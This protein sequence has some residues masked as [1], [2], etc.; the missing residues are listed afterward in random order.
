M[1]KGWLILL[2][3]VVISG[4]LVVL[5]SF[6]DVEANG[7][8]L[9]NSVI[10]VAKWDYVQGS[11]HVTVTPSAGQVELTFPDGTNMN[12]S[13]TYSFTLQLPR[14]GDTAGNGAIS[15]PVALSE[16]QPL[17]VVVSQNV[18]DVPS[19]LDNLKGGESTSPI[20]ID[21]YSIVV[22]GEA[23]ITASGFGIAL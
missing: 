10:A 14:T 13:S 16:D 15:G 21:F 11:L 8:V 17:N 19:Y 1:Q 18:G 6:H 4:Q 20:P 3:V 23:E 2:L 12:I 7:F 5:S 9:G 22:Q